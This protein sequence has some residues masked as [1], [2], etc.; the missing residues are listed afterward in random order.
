MK[1]FE[2][3]LRISLSELRRELPRSSCYYRSAPSLLVALNLIPKWK[4]YGSQTHVDSVKKIGGMSGILI[5]QSICRFL[6][7]GH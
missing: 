2:F 3:S 1:G 6:A 4:D 5:V 7:F